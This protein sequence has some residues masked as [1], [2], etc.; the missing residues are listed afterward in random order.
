[1]VGVQAAVGAG[2]RVYWYQPNCENEGCWTG[3]VR[4]FGEMS[5][6]PG[7]LAEDLSSVGSVMY[8]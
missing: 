4:V 6:L 5:A 3:A 7:M 2:L 8:R 1:M